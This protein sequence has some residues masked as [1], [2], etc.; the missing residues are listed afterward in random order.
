MNAGE[1]S[2]PAG[3]F[4]PEDRSRKLKKGHCRDRRKSRLWNQITVASE[5]NFSNADK[6]KNMTGQKIRALQ[7]P[8]V[9]PYKA[10]GKF[11]E[12]LYGTTDRPRSA[13][14]SGHAEVKTNCS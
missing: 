6:T 3:D 8:P 1:P 10:L 13:R 7:V 2:R 4:K 14:V 5:Q 12:A 11:S 9:V